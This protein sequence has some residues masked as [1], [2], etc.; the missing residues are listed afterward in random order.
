MIVLG[1]SC[2]ACGEI[3]PP[4]G[5]PLL[6]ANTNPFDE[7]FRG[8]GPAGAHEGALYEPCVSLRL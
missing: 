5:A 8:C 7:D 3:R 4:A 6:E 1:I 2:A